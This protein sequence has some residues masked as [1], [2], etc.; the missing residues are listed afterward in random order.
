MKAVAGFWISKCGL[1]HAGALSHQQ[2]TNK[3]RDPKIF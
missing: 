2:F 1:S 3:I